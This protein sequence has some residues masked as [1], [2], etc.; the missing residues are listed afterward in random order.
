MA[1]SLFYYVAILFY[2]FLLGLST[3]Y[4]QKTRRLAPSRDFAFFYLYIIDNPYMHPISF[5]GTTAVQRNLRRLLVRSLERA[6]LRNNRSW[7]RAVPRA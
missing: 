3:V 1:I 6:G 2:H 7:E 5:A 4:A